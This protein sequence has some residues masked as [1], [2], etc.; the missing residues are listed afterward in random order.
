M[1]EQATGAVGLDRPG[2]LRVADEARVRTLTFDRPEALNAC[3]EAL[4]D[5]LTEALLASA[6][7]PTVAVV[8]LTGAGRAF[9]AGTDLVEMAARVTD[10]DGF[11]AGIHGFLGLI[12]A[13]VAFPKPFVVAVNGLGLGI[14]ATILG[15]ADLAFMADTARLKC[16]FTSLGVAPEAASSFTFPALLG[17]QAA[18]WVLMSSEW[19]SAEECCAMGLV[20]KVTAPDEL[21]AEA[22]R[23]AEVVASK[24]ISSLVRTKA[25]I[26]APFVEQIAAARQREN[27]A[28]IELMGGP[29]NAEA[30]AAFA[31]GR[32]ADFTAL[33]PGW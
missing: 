15:F 8:L 21:L 14:G 9:C 26:V 31:E 10:P 24:P 4:Y 2:L 25:A 17:R 28:F 33:P 27:Q 13:L 11:Q 30:L 18:T 32:E 6:D 20:W 16:P 5:A 3:N 23:H 29:A 7:D 19:L 1:N 12:D 22:R